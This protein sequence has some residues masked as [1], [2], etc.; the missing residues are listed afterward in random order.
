MGI[1]LKSVLHRLLGLFLTGSAIPLLCAQT[2]PDPRAS[3]PFPVG[4]TTTV[5]VD[6][7][8]TDAFTKKART[9]VTEIWYPATDETRGLPKNRYRDFFSGGV[10][11][12][13][14]ALLSAAFRKSVEEIEKLY[15][16]QAVRDA[17]VRPG[18]YPLV[19]FSHG[20]GGTRTQNTFW[21]DYLASHGYVIASPDHTGNAR[22]T[23]LDGELIPYQ[24]GERA[25]S[26]ADRP[27]DLS[28]LL[29]QMGRWNGGADS[30]FA[31]RIDSA[32]AAATGMSYGAVSAIRAADADA[33]FRAVLTMAAA[34]PTHTN[35]T[36]PM[37]LMLGAEDNTIGPEG[38]R[39][40]RENHAIH[41]G[42]AFLLELKNGGHYSFTDMFKINKAFGDGIG[43]GKRRG[44]DQVVEFTPMELTYEIIN[45]YSVAF[46]GAYLKGQKE[47][48]PFLE[49]N[50]WPDA[51]EWK[52]TGLTP[53]TAPAGSAVR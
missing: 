36:V 5:F 15:W 30:R 53:G 48:L 44:T 10:T 52:A 50:H 20:N 39:R 37:L 29:E 51:L 8:R 49:K 34:P 13:A 38:N 2:A 47:Y 3:G 42:P 33:R 32:A 4:V 19:I 17:R 14:A 31:G 12:Q 9:L 24:A 23:I 22:F 21:F 26:G 27:R 18:K 7:S 25:N 45:S 43:S 40:I 46:L 6:A 11:P 28:F 16:N 41:T 1:R 35:L